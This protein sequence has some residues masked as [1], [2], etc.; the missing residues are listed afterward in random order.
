M[1]GF[2]VRNLKNR[3]GTWLSPMRLTGVP[4]SF[5]EK[6]IG[7]LGAEIFMMKAM[8]AIGIPNRMIPVIDPMMSRM[9]LMMRFQP[10]IGVVLSLISGMPPGVVTSIF[11][12]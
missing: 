7:A 3:N 1:F 6:R 4:S 9:R 10:S 2:I 8:M 12:R 11:V 5:L